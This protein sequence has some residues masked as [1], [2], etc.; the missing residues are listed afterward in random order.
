M[1]KYLMIA[2]FCLSQSPFFAF[3]YEKPHLSEDK[4]FVCDKHTQNVYFPDYGL[5]RF[6][7]VDSEASTFVHLKNLSVVAHIGEYGILYLCRSKEAQEHFDNA[8]EALID[9]IEHSVNAGISIPI[10][11]LAIIEG[12]KAVESWMEMAHEYSEGVRCEEREKQE[13]ENE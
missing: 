10:P 12:Y 2:G 3:A 11:P 1:K 4:F 6:V 5:D 9:A 7:L 13:L 8:K